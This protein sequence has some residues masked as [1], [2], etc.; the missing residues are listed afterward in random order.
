MIDD[1][2]RPRYWR[3]TLLLAAAVVA[4]VIICAI[5]LPLFAAE[6]NGETLLGFPLGFY[7]AAQG[8]IIVL[9]VT[10]FWTG[11]RQARTDRKFGATEDM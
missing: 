2:Q 9:I 4:V 3:H 8:V 6:F 1:E 11:H 5:V 7:A 10:V